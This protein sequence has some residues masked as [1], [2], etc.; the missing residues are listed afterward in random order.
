MQSAPGQL[1]P[2]P[3]G[4][5]PLAA[6]LLLLCFLNILALIALGLAY[7]A[8]VRFRRWATRDGLRQDAA[9]QRLTA[10]HRRLDL[11]VPKRRPEAAPAPEEPFPLERRAD[12]SDDGPDTRVLDGHETFLPVDFRHNEW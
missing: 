8:F 12:W 7:R 10:A 1:D 2:G 6:M 9:H 3:P 5:V 4:M 11:R